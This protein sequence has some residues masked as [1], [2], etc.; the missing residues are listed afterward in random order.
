VITLSNNTLLAL[1]QLERQCDQADVPLSVR[2]GYM[3]DCLALIAPR[4][5][6]AVRK[7]FDIVKT[8]PL[9]GAS[10]TAVKNVRRRGREWIAEQQQPGGWE[11]REVFA[12][13]AVLDILKERERA[14]I[15][16]WTEHFQFFLGQILH[17]E[18]SLNPPI[19]ALTQ[20]YFSSYLDSSSR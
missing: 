11:T 17:I 8:M 13:E 3:V 12:M 6:P 5:P 20:K 15:P 1:R 9:D 19:E 10:A 14:P 2:I 4:M 18:E 16:H 7:E